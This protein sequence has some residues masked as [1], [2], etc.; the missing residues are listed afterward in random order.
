MLEKVLAPGA[1]RRS[2]TSTCTTVR[3]LTE[4]E[5]F[6]PVLL[7]AGGAAGRQLGAGPHALC[8]RYGGIW[9]VHHGLWGVGGQAARRGGGGRGGGVVFFF[10]NSAVARLFG[11]LLASSRRD[12]NR[13]RRAQ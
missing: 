6:S 10:T 11:T 12:A 1:E 5:A 3:S 2:G 8:T 13:T 7:S 4:L 9:S